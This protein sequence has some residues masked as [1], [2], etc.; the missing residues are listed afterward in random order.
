MNRTLL[1]LLLGL[2]K[3]ESKSLDPVRNLLG[4]PVSNLGNPFATNAAQH[5]KIYSLPNVINATPL[6]PDDIINNLSTLQSVSAPVLDATEGILAFQTQPGTVLSTTIANVPHALSVRLEVDAPGAQ[7]AVYAHETLVTRGTNSLISFINIS[8]GKTVLNVVTQNTNSSTVTLNLPPDINSDFTAF[9]PPLPTWLPSGTMNPGYLDPITGHPGVQI[10][11]NNQTNVA[12]WDLYRVNQNQFGTIT[13][14]ATAN[15]N[16]AVTTTFSGTGPNLPL[17]GSIVIVSGAISIGTILSA[18]Y[19][20][21]F[22]LTNFVVKP[23]DNGDSV[24]SGISFGT[25]SFSTLA[26][27]YRNANDPIISFVDEKV[28]VGT[29][30]SY[31]IDSISLIDPFIK[32]DKISIQTVTTPNIPFIGTATLTEQSPGYL[33]L[34]LS[35]IGTQ[36]RYWSSWIRKNNWPTVQSGAAFAQLNNDYLKFYDE[37]INQTTFTFSATNGFW[38]G[39]VVA[40]DANNN[41]STRTLCSGNVTGIG[42]NSGVPTLT[43]IGIDLLTNGVGVQQNLLWWNTN[44]AAEKPIVGSG[45]QVQVLAT[46]TTEGVNNANITTPNPRFIWQ[47]YEDTNTNFGDTSNTKLLYGSMLDPFASIQ[48][49]SDLAKLNRV[50]KYSVWYYTINILSNDGSSTIGTYHTQIGGNYSSSASGGSGGGGGFPP[51]Q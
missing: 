16:Y 48:N 45:Y 39:E 12:G 35:N 28:Q 43:F 10:F 25:L 9:L 22:N 32:S 44:S 31:T 1:N 19:S 3:N 38:Y 6:S 14:W 41:S 18:S 50:P 17:P 33:T 26:V 30:Y 36:V 40:Y 15:G 2:I 34:A 13:Q 11:W 7:I 47:D 27:I 29:T 37:D 8:A 42:V 51:K 4:A 46:N 49:A 24:F 20:P 21:D 23:F 5:W